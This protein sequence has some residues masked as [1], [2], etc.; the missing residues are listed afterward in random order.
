[1]PSRELIG[2]RI[3]E[4]AEVDLTA[5]IVDRDALWTMIA[6]LPVRQRTVIVLRY[7]EDQ[8][9]DQIAPILGCAASTV[10]GLAARALAQLRTQIERPRPEAD[11]SG[12]PT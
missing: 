4:R 10:R 7:F 12:N 2:V 11:D 8:P 1:M 3:P 6:R 5:S 9:D